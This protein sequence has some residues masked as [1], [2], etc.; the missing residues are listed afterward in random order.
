M[1]SSGFAN[2]NDALTR[3]RASTSRQT[4]RWTRF[5]ACHRSGCYTR[6]S[7]TTVGPSYR[8]FSMSIL[9]FSPIIRCSF[10]RRVASRRVFARKFS[11]AST[12]AAAAAAAAAFVGRS[13]VPAATTTIVDSRYRSENKRDCNSYRAYLR[14]DVAYR[15]NKHSLLERSTFIR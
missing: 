9:R 8:A 6:C 15:E 14:S 1:P 2:A 10:H 4:V 3:A 11:S 7:A 5:G 13:S 12:A